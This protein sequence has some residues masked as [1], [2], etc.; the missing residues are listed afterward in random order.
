MTIT[1]LKNAGDLTKQTIYVDF[2]TPLFS[3]DGGRM[4]ST[5]RKYVR[6][7]I[8]GGRILDLD[9]VCISNIR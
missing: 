1:E 5:G 6:V 3:C 8:A 2:T 9:P 4:I 7:M